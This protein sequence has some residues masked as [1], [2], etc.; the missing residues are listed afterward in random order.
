[1]EDSPCPSK[2]KVVVK[3]ARLKKEKEETPAGEVGLVV[4]SLLQVEETEVKPIIDIKMETVTGPPDEVAVK[5]E[6]INA[7][8]QSSKESP[9]FGKN[10]G[11]PPAVARLDW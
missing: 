1:M 7:I 5:E 4:D 2:R 9:F 6:S 11:S 3:Q 10:G 8:E